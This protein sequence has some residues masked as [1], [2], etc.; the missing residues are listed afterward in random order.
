MHNDLIYTQGNTYTVYRNNTIVNKVKGLI[1]NDSLGK[2]IALYPNELVNSGDIL[3]N[4]SNEKFYITHIISPAPQ[5]VTHHKKAYF[6]FEHE[7]NSSQGTNIVISPQPPQISQTI[8]QNDYSSRE[9]NFTNN[10]TTHYNM[11]QNFSY[12]FTEIINENPEFTKELMDFL[13]ELHKQK[14][15]PRSLK[16]KCGEF[17]FKHFST[18]VKLLTYLPAVIEKIKNIL[19]KQ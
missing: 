2:Y 5:Q 18:I 17:I 14:N 4:E 16:K 6:S 7:L 10:N 3:I 13:N 15:T 12:G 9:N 1:R 19:D 8:N 11:V